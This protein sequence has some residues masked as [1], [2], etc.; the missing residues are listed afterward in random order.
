MLQFSVQTRAEI[1]IW[2]AIAWPTALTFMASIAMGL[3]D[4]AVIG[5]LDTTKLAAAAM[6]SIW[7]EVTSLM[8]YGVTDAIRILGS[9]AVGSGDKA[10]AGLWCQTGM[11]VATMLC[12]PVG[13]SWLYT[14]DVLNAIPG[15]KEDVLDHAS[16]FARWSVLWLWPRNMFTAV[17]KYM[18]ANNVVLPQLVVSGV[19]VAVNVGSNIA[20]V[21]TGIPGVFKPLGFI[22]SPMS[23]AIAWWG[24]LLAISVYCMLKNKT[25]KSIA[26]PGWSLGA[27]LVGSKLR[28]FLGI[29]LPL[30][31]GIALEEIQIE[32]V[33]IMA[34]TMGTTAI[35]AHNVALQVFFFLSSLEMAVMSATAIRVGHHLGNGDPSRARGVVRVG[36]MFAGASAVMVTVT[37]ITLRDELGVSQS[38]TTPYNAMVDFVPHTSSLITPFDYGFMWLVVCPQRLWLWRT[39]ATFAD[40]FDF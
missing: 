24:Q 9:Q 29:A 1:P 5:H 12:I 15:I 26:W 39:T 31:V 14:R 23:T 20:L 33:T 2:W 27:A 36:A 37:L 38:V 40:M 8:I 21:L 7:L 35:A 13:F 19:F 25:T 28:A 34:G 11:F 6:S 3:T 10:L 32:T 30:G 4:L 22:G 16:V 18:Q 17:H